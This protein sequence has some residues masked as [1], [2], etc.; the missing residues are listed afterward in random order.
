MRCEGLRETAINFDLETDTL[1][2]RPHYPCIYI[3]LGLELL[4]DNITSDFDERRDVSFIALI[5]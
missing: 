4:L 2:N 3:T 5:D 1:C